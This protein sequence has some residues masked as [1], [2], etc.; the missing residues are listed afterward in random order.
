M[1]GGMRERVCGCFRPGDAIADL[2][3]ADDLAAERW[4]GRRALSLADIT[5]WGRSMLDALAA[6]SGETGRTRVAMRPEARIRGIVQ[7]GPARFDTARADAMGFVREGG[8]ES[9]VARLR[10]GARALTMRCIGGGR[11]CLA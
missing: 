5:V 1:A 3:H 7:T 4:Q 2:V 9:I 10:E 6:V 8:F 11:G